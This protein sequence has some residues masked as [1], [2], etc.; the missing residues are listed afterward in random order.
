M[1]VNPALCGTLYYVAAT[2]AEPLLHCNA[3]LLWGSLSLAFGHA[4]SPLLCVN[5]HEVAW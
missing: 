1:F 3:V 2:A 4:C 5:P